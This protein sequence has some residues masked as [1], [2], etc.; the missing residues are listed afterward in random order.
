MVG[1]RPLRSDQVLDP[2]IY[3]AALLPVLLAVMVV[4]F[5][6]SDRPRPIGTTLAPDAFDGDAAARTL[7]GLADRYP[8]RRAGDSG[9]AA[10]ATDIETRLRNALGQTGIVRRQEFS[11]HTL[12]GQRDLV[13]VVA[14]RP[15]A[16][17]GQL[18]VVA[19]RDAAGRVAKAELSGTAALLELAN[20]AADG[21]FHRTITLISTTGGS[22]GLAGAIHAANQI[23]GPVSAVLVLGDLASAKIRKPWVV[24]WVDGKGLAPLQLRRTVE[25]AV[26]TEAGSDPGGPR[27]TTQFARQALGLSATEQG[28]L[29]GKGLPAVL[30]SASG[31]RGPTAE[32]AIDGAHLATFGRAALRAIIALDNGPTIGGG[33]SSYIVTKRKL[34]PGWA[35]RLLSAALLL[36]VWLATLDGYARARRRQ[37]QVGRWLVWVLSC[38]LPFALACAAAVVLGLSGLIDPAPHAPLPPDVVSVDGAALAALGVLALVLALSFLLMR[39]LALRVAGPDGKDPPTGPGPAAAVAIVSGVLTFVTWALNPFAAMLLVPAAHL[40]LFAV[41]PEVRLRRVVAIGLVLAGL[42]APLLAAVVLAQQIGASLPEGAWLTI[43]AIA[44]GGVG[45]LAW[46]AWCLIAG[47]TVAALLI[48]RVPVHHDDPPVAEVTSRGPLSY[49]GPGSLGGTESAIRR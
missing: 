13:N 8:L 29:G 44:G 37:G 32:A 33:P 12:D 22:G 3:R 11:G 21:R 9:D 26:R 36:P 43:V 27:A 38:A 20:V 40:W 6:L 48:A 35:I 25:L 34:L 41:A 10:L 46:L 23:S 18:V 14:T 19:H 30:L 45:P 5:S 49:A 15:G 39:P 7:D 17:G 42:L 31:E 28:A 4:A 16:P 1:A 47:C 24:P 2:R